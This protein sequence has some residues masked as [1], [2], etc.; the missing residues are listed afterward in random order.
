MIPRMPYRSA[1]GPWPEAAGLSPGEPSNVQRDARRDAWTHLGKGLLASAL[2]ILAAGALV[3]GVMSLLGRNPAAILS[4]LATGPF[5]DRFRFVES[6]ARATPLMLCGLAVTLAFR[7]GAWNIGVE[8]QYLAGAM[9]M[10]AIGTAAGPWPGWLLVAACLVASAAAGALWAVPAVALD[11]RRGVP[12]VLST[13][14]LNFVALHLVQ[15]LTRGPLQGDDPAAPESAPLAPQAR[16]FPLVTGTDFHW[17]FGLALLA[18]GACSVLLRRSTAGFALRAAGLNPVAA[19]WSGIRVNRVKFR[20]MCLSG[21]LGGL[22]GG[23][24]VAGV[25]HLLRDD[26]A[27]GFGYVGIAVALLGRLDPLG[28]AVAAV[29]LGMLDVGAL[30]LERQGRLG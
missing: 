14:L 26:A 20:V 30:H 25:H 22:A 6:L 29:A 16:L 15:Y 9:A 19:E 12:L 5:A 7:A 11:N 3:A 10:T 4:A 27:E 24:Q 8:G 2:S 17:G 1:D 23:M 21:A 13:I 18:A 28:V